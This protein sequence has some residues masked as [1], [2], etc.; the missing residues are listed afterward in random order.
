MK[1]GEIN[2]G[3]SLGRQDLAPRRP[4]GRPTETK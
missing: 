4:K 1:T 3:R 2:V